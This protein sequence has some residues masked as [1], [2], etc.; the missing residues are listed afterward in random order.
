MSELSN[1]VFRELLFYECKIRIWGNKITMRLS[2]KFWKDIQ[3]LGIT[4]FL[5]GVASV[6]AFTMPNN[7]TVVLATDGIEYHISRMQSSH[8]QE[9]LSE[10]NL[11]EGVSNYFSIFLG[12]T[13]ARKSDNLAMI[14]ARYNS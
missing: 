10:L 7:S 2:D 6:G 9:V 5:I 8:L 3:S 12:E 4:L 1:K 13:R 11:E 14:A